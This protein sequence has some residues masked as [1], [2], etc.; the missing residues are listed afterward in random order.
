MSFE[1]GD[2]PVPDDSV[3][4]AVE[5]L[6]GLGTG[7]LGH[8]TDF[9]HA[10]GLQPIQR[11][12][13]A[14]GSAFTVHLPRLDASALHYALGLISPGEILVV[15]TSGEQVRATFG[16]IVAH[17]AVRAGVA[18]VVIDGPVTDWAE[19]T[20]LG[21][22][23]WCRGLTALTARRLYIEGGIQVPVQV[24][25]VV[26]SPG[27]LVFADSDGVFF[28]R[29]GEAREVAERVAATEAREPGTKRR[30]DAGEAL[31]D[32]NGTRSRIEPMLTSYNGKAQTDSTRTS[33][34]AGRS[35][36]E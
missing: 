15:D 21:L 12:A 22:P 3:S 36:A 29:R 7:T 13:K 11:P 28:I 2:R 5:M 25:G 14:V 27:D 33:T 10:A 31:P 4:A 24:A 34:P 30:L 23:V 6:K 8:L 19:L 32:I 20:E 35:T 9:G 17:A 26:V 16:G 1:L 18:G